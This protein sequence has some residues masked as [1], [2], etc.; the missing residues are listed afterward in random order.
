MCT[1]LRFE[2]RRG[3]QL[4]KSDCTSRVHTRSNGGALWLGLAKHERSQR[5]NMR[6]AV[7][8]GTVY[9]VS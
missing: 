1:I 7:W 5:T 6:P 2:N 8:P 4:S 3:G 9:R